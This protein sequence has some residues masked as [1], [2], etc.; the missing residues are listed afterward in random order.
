MNDVRTVDSIVNIFKK[1]IKQRRLC[2]YP[3][4]ETCYDGFAWFSLNTFS[5][6]RHSMVLKLGRNT[7]DI[8]LFLLYDN[9]F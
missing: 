9:C 8:V 4:L 3:V 7:S 2:F 6:S 1:G 5:C